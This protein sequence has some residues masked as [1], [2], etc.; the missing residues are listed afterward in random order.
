MQPVQLLADP[1]RRPRPSRPHRRWRKSRMVG[2]QGV[3]SRS[4]S[5][6]Q[7]EE[8]CTATQTGTPSAPA[9]WASAVSGVITRSRLRI[10]AAASARSPSRRP[11][12]TTGKRPAALSSCSA[13]KPFCR[14]KRRTP[15]IRASGSKRSSRNDR[16]RSF[17]W[18][19][20]PCQAMPT[21]RPSTR[22]QLLA[23]SGHGRGIGGQVG[24]LRGDGL[25][26]RLEDPRQAHE[27]GVTVMIGDGRS[28]G[29]HL[30]DAGTGRQERG[31]RLGTGSRSPGPRGRRRRGQSG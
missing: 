12:S 25:D 27:R 17:L 22:P 5:Q 30:V 2:Y 10:K 13:P 15:S 26:R 23:P 20:L 4:R 28:L 18:S 7:S 6:R 1:S 24:N 14:L 9:R 8:N 21:F 16:W 29:D 11:R 3:S 19:G 31:Q